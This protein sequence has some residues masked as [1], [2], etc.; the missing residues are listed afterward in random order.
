[1]SWFDSLA[2]SLIPLVPMPIMRRLSVR[3]IAGEKREDALQRGA[4]LI[5]AGYGVIY[6]QLGEAV[7]D[8]QEVQAAKQ[9]YLDLLQAL[10]AQEKDRNISLKPTQMGLNLSEDLCTAT[11]RTILDRAATCDAFT[12]FE[13]EESETVDGT[14][15]V[16][17]YLRQSHGAAV[18]VVLQSML[19]R[20]EQDARDLLESDLPLNVRLVKGIYV[21]PAE[22]AYQDGAEVNASYLRILRLL[23]EGGAFVAAATHDEKLIAGLQE[24]LKEHP[25]YADRCEIQMLLGVREELRQEARAQ[26]LPVRVYLPYGVAWHKYVVRRLKKN[27]KL[28]RYAMFGMFKKQEKLEGA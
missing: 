22:I 3:Y 6:D 10:E 27:P 16:F 14:L 18:G 17:H 1:M 25:Q 8:E 2:A 12:R 19:F 7:A 24:I 9:E 4:K 26:G 11:V 5:S 15:R 20:T 21:E 28:A 23:L 13:M